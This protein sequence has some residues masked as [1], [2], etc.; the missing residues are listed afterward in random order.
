[1]HGVAKTMKA[2]LGF[3]V[4]VF[5]VSLET[6]V[7]DQL[8]AEAGYGFGSSYR[9]EGLFLRY[10]KDAPPL[11]DRKSFYDVA[12]AHWNGKNWNNAISVARGLQWDLRENSYV[13]ASLGLAYADHVTGNFGT[14]AQFVLRVAAGRSFGDH[15]LSVGVIHYSNGHILVGWDG[16][17]SGENYLTVQLAR[18]L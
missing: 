10:R 3:T 2:Y 12:L 9:A 7:A 13:G 15:D 16:P 17:N 18:R 4:L 5:L 11:W 6:A 1:M 14:R 8:A